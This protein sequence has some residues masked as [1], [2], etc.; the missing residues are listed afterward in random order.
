MQTMTYKLSSDGKVAV[1]QGVLPA[2]VD[3][4][5]HLLVNLV[6]QSPVSC[7]AQEREVDVGERFSTRCCCK[8]FNE[9]SF[10]D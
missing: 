4:A 5:I 3:V 6:S 7:D 8:P 10:L 2:K 1:D 9:R